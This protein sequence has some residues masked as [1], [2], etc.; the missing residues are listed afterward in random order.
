MNNFKPGQRW[1]CDVD[2]QL[3]LGTVQSVE[4]RIVSIAFLASGETRTYSRQS[5]PLKR[6][7]FNVGD[8]ITSLHGTVIQILSVEKNDGLLTYTGKDKNGKPVILPEH[9]LAHHIQFNRPIERLLNQHI[10]ADKWFQ[11][12][13]QT[14]LQRNR[15]VNNSLYGLVGSRTSLIPHQLYISHEVGRRYAPRVLLADEV[16]LGKTI[17][18]GMILHQQLLTERAKR[19]LIAVPET[20]IHQ[21]LVEML[22]RFNLRF[23]LFDDERYAVLE[24][25]SADGNPFHNEQLILCSL[26][27]LCNNPKHL[28]TAL[29]GDWDLLVVDEAHHL[30]WSEQASSPAYQAIEQLAAQTRGVLLLTATPEQLGKASH[31]ARLRLLDPDR[32]SDFHRFL[33]EE[34]TFEPIANVVEALLDGHKLNEE[35]NTTILSIENNPQTQSLLDLL[36]K[37][38]TTDKNNKAARQALAALMLDRHGTGRILFRNT[39]VTV[40]GFPERELNMVRLPLPASYNDC[41]T[42]FETTRLSEPELLLY[43]ELLY[44]VNAGTD[45]P[46]WIDI[47]PRINWLHETMRQLKPEKILVITASAQT[48]CDIAHALRM[49]TSQ[50]YPVFHEDMSLLERDRA[51]AFFADREAG[52]QVLICSEIGSEGRNFQFAHHLV[53]FD[54][55]FNPDLLEQR[56]GRLDRIGQTETIKIHLPYLQ[57][58]AQ[59]L[60]LNWYHKGLNAFKKTCPAG[61]AVFQKF[62]N[63]LINSFHQRNPDSTAFSKLTVHTQEANQALN[64]ALD[65]GR[66]RLL[67]YNSCRPQLAEQL[68]KAGT[69]QDN[70]NSLQH[71]MDSAFD[72]FGVHIEEHRHMSYYIEPSELMT[73]AFPGLP[74]DG[75]TITYNRNVALANEDMQFL[76]WEHPM[77]IHAMDRVVDNETGNATV[78]SFSHPDTRPG[79]LFLECLFILDISTEIS[80]TRSHNQPSI[81]I[82]TIIDEHGRSDYAALDHDTINQYLRTLSPSVS[83]QVIELKKETIKD[84]ITASE[85][86]AKIQMPAHTKKNKEKIEEK[87]KFEIERLKA[88]KEINP[89]VRPEEIL[90]FE[91]QLQILTRAIDT[92]KT[93]LDAMRVIVAT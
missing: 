43:P 25:N 88:L 53:L 77:V 59:A 21:W 75:L 90:F 23:S 5:A 74:D 12:R 46:K 91:Q 72:C 82:R 11:I 70:D 84:M 60:M 68:Y 87:F 42:V 61:S 89:S 58:S 56:I 45:D 52:C 36:D 18:A 20:L 39:R 7:I 35:I 57:H 14:W 86:L 48:A 54:L 9:Q 65:R 4:Q 67:E 44:Q 76:T 73:S 41:L 28:R 26:G 93:R 30:E 62:K 64:E 71:Y 15:L 49:L 3:G 81:M 51:A 38:D 29:Q 19:V 27:F 40:Q 47:D 80:V 8:T 32:F 63:Q 85:Q 1:I 10:D 22:R 83:K 50:H 24:E 78:S 16:G 6:V 37:T 31:F 66:D 2:L 69:S 17:E 34:Q 13:Y 92:A 33:A 79:T 55:P